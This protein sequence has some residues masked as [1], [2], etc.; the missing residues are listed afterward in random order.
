MRVHIV[1]RQLQPN[2]ERAEIGP[3]SFCG[4]EGATHKGGFTAISGQDYSGTFCNKNCFEK[5]RRFKCY[6]IQLK[7]AKEAKMR[8]HLSDIDKIYQGN[9]AG[10][11]DGEN[12]A[13]N[14]IMGSV[15]R[16]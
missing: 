12:V 10:N 7:H 2:E 9:K 14:G 13:E 16:V 5:W 11:K 15:V 6:L 3:C 8:E 4:F 1:Q